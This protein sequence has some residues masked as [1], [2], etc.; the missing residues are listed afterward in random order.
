[1]RHTRTSDAHPVVT[2][3][4]CIYSTKG[5]RVRLGDGHGI[6]SVSNAGGR[7]VGY[8]AFAAGPNAMLVYASGGSA[9]QQPS[10][11]WITSNGSGEPTDCRWRTLR[12][13]GRNKR[14]AAPSAISPLGG[15]L[16]ITVMRP[17]KSVPF[18][19]RHATRSWDGT[20]TRPTL[21]QYFSSTLKLIG[22]R[23]VP[24]GHSPGDRQCLIHSTRT[25]SRTAYSLIQT[26]RI[27]RKPETPCWRLTRRARRTCG[28]GPAASCG[29]GSTTL[30][31]QQN[32]G[33]QRGGGR[34]RARS[35]LRPSR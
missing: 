13:C 10:S 14:G 17:G 9:T 33:V 27:G 29:I 6:P 1:M 12:L 31:R 35:D 5:T 11:A 32:G 8:M 16:S 26:A 18:F 21:S 3:R 23:P 19:V 20:R 15:C 4:R 2:S 25:R 24:C 30:W 22:N 7:T 28:I 34:F